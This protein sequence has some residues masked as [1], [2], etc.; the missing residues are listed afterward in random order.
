VSVTGL[1]IVPET[2]DWLFP[3]NGYY[4]DQ[5]V[6]IDARTAAETADPHSAPVLCTYDIRRL[7]DPPKPDEDKLDQLLRWLGQ[8]DLTQ[9]TCKRAGDLGKG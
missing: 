5:E 7:L 8:Q 9:R 1:D 4:V 3:R 6:T 2:W